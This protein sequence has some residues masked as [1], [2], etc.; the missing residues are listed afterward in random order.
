[1]PML[2]ISP[3]SVSSRGAGTGSSGWVCSDLF[4]HTSQLK[5]IEKLFLSPGTIMGAGGLP[6]SQWR[7]DTVGDLT[8]A[9]P[10]LSA[11]VTKKQP[12]V[13]TSSSPTQPLINT[14]CIGFQLNEVNLRNPL[15]YP[16]PSPQVAPAAGAQTFTPTPT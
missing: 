3:F 7:Y 15:P 8:S 9:L 16:V 4:D 11:P 12:L 6:M 2:V 10:V 13:P 14:E 1:V 5:F